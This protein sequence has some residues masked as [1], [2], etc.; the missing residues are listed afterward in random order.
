MQSFIGIKIDSGQVEEVET[1]VSF[2]P[3][4][5][6]RVENLEL[7]VRSQNCLK[8]KISFMLVI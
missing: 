8:M 1:Q 7:S 3:R 6:M 4:L 5:L 2:D